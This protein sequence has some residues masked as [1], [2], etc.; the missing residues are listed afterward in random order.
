MTTVD[1]AHRFASTAQSFARRHETSD[2]LVAVVLWS[3]G[4]LALMNKLTLCCNLRQCVGQSPM[5]C[6]DGLPKIKQ[7]FGN[8]VRPFSLFTASLL[9]F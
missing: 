9:V 1:Y 8:G 2:G 6:D 5:N 4:G 3:V 7:C